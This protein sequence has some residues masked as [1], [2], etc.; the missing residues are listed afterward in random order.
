MNRRDFLHRTARPPR[1]VEIC[2]ERLY[3]KYVDARSEGR[4][5][6]LLQSLELELRTADE[7]RLTGRE[8]LAREDIRRDLGPVLRICGA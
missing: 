6:Q 2:C 4:L 8:W 3:M 5:Q 7:V 1:I